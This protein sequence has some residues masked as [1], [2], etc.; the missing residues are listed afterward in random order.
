MPLFPFTPLSLF[1]G[2]SRSLHQALSPR[3]ENRVHGWGG[4]AGGGA[5]D[6]GAPRREGGR[7]AGPGHDG[8]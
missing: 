6:G 2:T 7:E 3:R 8:G 5:R 1:F 4:R